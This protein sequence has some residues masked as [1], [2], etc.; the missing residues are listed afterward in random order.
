MDGRG[1]THSTGGG[2]LVSPIR[3]CPWL[4]AGG[5]RLPSVQHPWVPKSRDLL[6]PRLG[7]SVASVWGGAGIQ[8]VEAGALH[9]GQLNGQ[10]LLHPP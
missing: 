3:G 1:G 9:V 6:L 5:P 8:V 4:C 10:R 2:W 7:P